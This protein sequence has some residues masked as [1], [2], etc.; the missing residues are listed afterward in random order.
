MAWR[1]FP[2]VRTKQRLR[3]DRLTPARGSKSLRQSVEASPG[4][5][6]QDARSPSRAKRASPPLTIRQRR[7]T[8]KT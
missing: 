7:N 5:S 6:R 3:A 2:A 1:A 4:S 8:K